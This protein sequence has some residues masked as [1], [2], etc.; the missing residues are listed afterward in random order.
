VI[1]LTQENVFNFHDLVDHLY[2]QYDNDGEKASWS[3]VRLIRVDHRTPDRIYFKYDFEKT[4]K[5]IIVK[6]PENHFDMRSYH[7]KPAYSAPIPLGAKKMKDL[8]FFLNQQI[9]HQQHVSFYKSFLPEETEV[10]SQSNE[11]E[12]PDE[13][14]PSSNKKSCSEEGKPASKKKKPASK[15]KASHGK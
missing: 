6:P 2:W 10:E 12:K 7:L 4:E 9:I 1:K 5:V 3:T 8:Q 15:A 11:K 13:T 14:K